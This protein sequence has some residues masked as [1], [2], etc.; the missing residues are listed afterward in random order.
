MSSFDEET[1]DLNYKPFLVIDEEPELKTDIEFN[2]YETKDFCVKILVRLMK[3]N[4]IR[5]IIA[6]SFSFLNI[7]VIYIPEVFSVCGFF[8]V[9]GLYCFVFLGKFF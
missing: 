6:L 7:I 4:K 3:G 9:F 2:D 5:T 8:P 1:K